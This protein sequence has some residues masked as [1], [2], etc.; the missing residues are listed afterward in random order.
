[1]TTKEKHISMLRGQIDKLDQK[2]FDLESWKKYTIVLLSAIFG[3]D[4]QKI[5]QVEKIEYEY[6]SWS[7]RD[8]TGHSSYLE[9]CKKLGREILQVAIMELED[10]GVEHQQRTHQGQIDVNLIIDAL[11]D[12]LKGTEYKALMKLLKSEQLPEEKSRQLH[13]ILKTLEPETIA[14]ILQGILLHQ[15]FAQALPEQ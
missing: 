1:M 11:K 5:R 3:D 10:F 14:A 7:L 6:N 13:D 9:S 12:E 15:D 4:S 8:T 2:P